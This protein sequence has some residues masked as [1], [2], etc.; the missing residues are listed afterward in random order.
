MKDLAAF[1][2]SVKAAGLLTPATLL[3][4]LA[5]KLPDFDVDAELA[6]LQAE[7][8]AQAQQQA[9]DRLELQRIAANAAA[10]GEDGPDQGN[11]DMPVMAGKGHGG[12]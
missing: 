4:I 11:E 8:D 5:T 12:A 7:A 10:A 3:R 1:A 6:A 9:A 2:A